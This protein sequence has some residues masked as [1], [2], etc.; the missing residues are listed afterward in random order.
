M[1][2]GPKWPR[3]PELA[4]VRYRTDFPGAAA[5][6]AL[7]PASRLPI[8]AP[9]IHDVG[10]CMSSIDQV[11]AQSNEEPRQ[12]QEERYTKLMRAIA[13]LYA[14]RN[15]TIPH[16]V[17]AQR[18]RLTDELCEIVRRQGMSDIHI[19][20]TEGEHLDE[21]KNLLIRE[22]D[23]RFKNMLS[24]ISVIASRTQE[25][26]SSMA[27]FVAGLDGRIKALMTTHELLSR[28]S[29]HGVSLADLVHQE[30][31]PYAAANNT[32]IKG[33]DDI[34]S[35]DAG[36]VIGMVL[37]E[38]ATNA[39]KYGALSNKDGRVWVS[40]RQQPNGQCENP[41]RLEWQERGGP[42]V[43]PPSQCGYG[44]S[45]IRDLIPYELGGTV[46]LVHSREGVRCNLEIPAHWIA[47]SKPRSQPI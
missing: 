6:R 14:L 3:N 42:P 7:A 10:Q 23:H 19:D 1:S 20:V 28:R 2:T 34:L 26:S 38:L 22:L 32:E 8:L 29:W 9:A 13:W 46:E 5:E 41:L 36:Q 21:H 43:V 33:S 44:S 25:N 12:A 37:H 11:G 27:D 30:L 39:A 31:A 4:F 40:W 18:S 15:T 47:N 17:A 45:V 16:V 24:V 35:A